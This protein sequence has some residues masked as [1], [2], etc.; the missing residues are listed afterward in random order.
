MSARAQK[1]SGFLRHFRSEFVVV[2]KRQLSQTT[3][4]SKQRLVAQ[5]EV[6]AFIRRCMIASGSKE[7]HAIAVADNLTAADYRGHYSHGLN[8]LGGFQGCAGVLE[9]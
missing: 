8:R 2:T 5:D 7:H 1:L 6:K 4:D 9:V 3:G